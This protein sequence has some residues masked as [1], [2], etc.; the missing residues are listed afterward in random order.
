[1]VTSATVAAAILVKAIDDHIKSETMR[2]LTRNEYKAVARDLLSVA[3]AS[4]NGLPCVHCIRGNCSGSYHGES[5]FD[6]GATLRDVMIYWDGETDGNGF[7]RE[8]LLDLWPDYLNT[9]CMIF[10]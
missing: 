10:P 7:I 8:E 3:H 5:A 6:Q 2:S 1:M 9:A 4:K